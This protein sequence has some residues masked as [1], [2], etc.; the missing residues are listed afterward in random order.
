MT[1]FMAVF[2]SSKEGSVLSWWA[3][4]LFIANGLL[5][6]W[7]TTWLFEKGRQAMQ[8]RLLGE[9]IDLGG[10][11]VSR[12]CMNHFSGLIADGGM[13]Y[14]LR[15]KMVFIPHSLNFSRKTVTILLSDIESIS[16][17]KVWKILSV[18][19]KITLKSGKVERF[20]IDYV[21]KFYSNA[22]M[23]AQGRSKGDFEENQ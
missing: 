12:G 23:A 5:Y 21:D 6:G 4:L 2:I 7:L 19:V 10:D 15:N 18:G 22:L 1:V 9:E 17:Y 3:Y 13:G 8:A 16:G 14:L 11:I 20:V